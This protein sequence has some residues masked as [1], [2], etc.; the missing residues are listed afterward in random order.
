MDL[1]RQ[2]K[3]LVAGLGVLVLGAG[4]Y[5]LMAGRSSEP[6]DAETVAVAPTRVMDEKPPEPEK[7]IKKPRADRPEPPREKPR[8]REPG[9]RP[10]PEKI[11]RTKP[12]PKEERQKT[13]P[14]AS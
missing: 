4:S 10:A 11:K 9:S 3:W 5:F 7:R 13:G 8:V 12:R 2:Q 1:V 6:Q 14:P